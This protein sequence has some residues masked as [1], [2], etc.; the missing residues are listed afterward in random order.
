MDD[1][2]IRRATRRVEGSPRRPLDA[3]DLER[4]CPPAPQAAVRVA[5]GLSLLALGR[6][7]SATARPSRAAFVGVV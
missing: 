3:A 6:A 5:R 1:G 2:A 7:A 4:V